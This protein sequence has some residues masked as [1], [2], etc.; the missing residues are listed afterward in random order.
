MSP[1]HTATLKSIWMMT[2]R[3]ELTRL[4]NCHGLPLGL[5]RGWGSLQRFITDLKWICCSVSNFNSIL[6][7]LLRANTSVLKGPVHLNPHQCVNDCVLQIT[8][9][10]KCISKCKEFV[11]EHLFCLSAHWEL[12]AEHFDNAK[13]TKA[14]RKTF[15]TF[16]YT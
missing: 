11:W 8:C 5:G 13:W 4:K 2:T 1:A 9:F 15:P 7:L 12:R 6:A 16:K 3:T 10:S 14:P